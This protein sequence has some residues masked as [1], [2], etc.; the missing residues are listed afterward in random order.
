MNFTKHLLS[1]LITFALW[2]IFLLFGL[3]SNYY[4]AWS[5]G[6]QVLLCIFTLILLLPVSYV[7]L[8]KVWQQDFL[9]SSLWMA[10]YASAP[11]ILYD[12]VYIG[13]IQGQGVT[14]LFTHWYLS[15]FYLLVWL[16]I[17]LLGWVLQKRCVLTNPYNK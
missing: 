5:F 17:P 10:F 8:M 3:S 13:V 9:K 7:V 2:F 14:F 16:E 15:L 12:Y 11:L 4:Q 6:A 1:L